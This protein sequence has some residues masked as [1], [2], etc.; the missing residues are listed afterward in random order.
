M[1]GPSQPVQYIVAVSGGV[2]SVVLLDVL[3]RQLGLPTGSMVVAHFDH[4]IREDSASDR[5]F[6]KELAGKYGLV[7]E[8]DEGKLGANVSEAKAREARYAFLRRVKQ[9]HGARRLVTAHHQD[10]ML[11]TALINI[12]RGTGRRGLSSLQST[13]EIFRP[14]LATPKARLLEYAREHDLQWREDSTNGDR[15]YLRNYIRHDI[16]AKTDEAVRKQLLQLVDKAHHHNE[17]IEQ[18]LADLP[19]LRQATAELNRP[20]YIMLPH[21][22]AREVMAG[23]LRSHGVHS[24]DS[25]LLERLTVAAKSLA[26]GKQI[27]V[28]GQMVL[29]VSRDKITLIER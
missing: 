10:D 4:G 20:W 8:Y 1:Q 14:L 13:D 3:A 6:V 16:L 22:V 19:Q 17:A 27:D 28:N 23:W 7:F 18:L 5:R 15:R 24:F 26:P 12:M 29:A 9:A 2:D 21:D 25:K 11:E